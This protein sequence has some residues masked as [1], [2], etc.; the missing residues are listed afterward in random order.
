MIKRV[1][2]IENGQ[3]A[4]YFDLLSLCPLTIAFS[5]ISKYKLPT[6]FIERMISSVSMCASCFE[7]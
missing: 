6:D 1:L 3:I 4:S 2:E 5:H 7:L